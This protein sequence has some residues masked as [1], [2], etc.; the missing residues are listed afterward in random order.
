MS[1]RPLLP[2]ALLAALLLAAMTAGAGAVG[3]DP[4]LPQ[5]WGLRQIGAPTAWAG[6]AVVGDGVPIAIVDTGVDLGHEDLRD[7]I[8][9]AVT[10]VDTGGDPAKC[11]A[12]GAD[13]EGHGSHVAGIAAASANSVGVSGVAPGARLIVVR[14]FTKST[15][16]VT[17][18]A[19]FSATSDDIN[20][21]IRWTIAHVPGKGA[22][23][24]SVGGNYVVT[25]VF[26]ASFADGIEEAWKAGW[27]PVLASGNENLLGV[28]SSNYGSLDALV[29]GATGPDDK[30]ASY[31]SETGD[32][33]WALL[34]P[35]GDATS[36]QDE[37]A[38]CILSTYKGGQYGYLQGT[39]MATPHVAGAVALL[40][41]LGLSNAAT[42]QRLLDTA[43]RKVACGGNCR[44]RLDVA[45]ATAGLAPA[46][47]GGGGGPATTAAPAPGPSA[48]IPACP[49]SG[50]CARS[51]PRR[52]G[53]VAPWSARACPSPSSTR[54]STSA[55][56]TCAT[57]SAPPSPASTPAVTRRSARPTG[58]TSRA[59]APT[60]PGSRR[61]RPTPWACPAWRRARG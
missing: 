18:E 59:T 12:D 23:N 60:W 6:G 1:R 30:V 28:E 50:A 61:R 58:P 38:K 4:G 11:K 26:G 13:I 20:A 19:T 3:T 57:G 7:R 22:I 15:N 33:K 32:A 47:G 46:S 55:T 49:S 39:S 2:V 53:P 25:S 21:G 52:R 17:G 42:V 34:A 29:V 37:A 27:V 16:S 35:G 8:G 9:A 31:S 43:D 48:P 41:K 5:Q 10:C 40:M 36:C 14:V 45:K 44:G 54:A 56:R 24:L 51:A